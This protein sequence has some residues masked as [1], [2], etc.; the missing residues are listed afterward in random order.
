MAKATTPNL[1]SGPPPSKHKP[2]K[3]K[4]FKNV[5]GKELKAHIF[6]PENFNQPDIRPAFVFF[7]PGGWTMGEPEWGYD[8]CHHFSKFD[9]VAISFEYRLSA[10]SGYCPAEAVLDAK[11]AMRWT[12]QHAPE[13]GIDSNRVIAGGISA[14]GHL[15]ACT[16]M[17]SGV[18]DPED[19]RSYSPV[20]QALALQSATVNPAIDGHFLQLLQ[21]RVKPEEL[22]PAHHVKAGLPPM[23]LVHG[24][25]DEIVSYDS[26]KEFAFEM[27]KVGNNCKL[28]TFEGVDHFFMNKSAQR[29]AIKLIDE[30]VT[31]FVTRT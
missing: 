4:V 26:V 30:F 12:R 17:I 5:S 16:A 19:N 13:F 20:P 2:D 14:G 31:A 29:R 15:A 28:H 25:A 1:P 8:L 23:C 18:D 3:V 7:H 9:M 11:S 27:E 21:G 10:I 24:T 22:S 6:F